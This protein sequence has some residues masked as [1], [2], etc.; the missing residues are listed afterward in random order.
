MSLSKRVKKK[1]SSAII[2]YNLIENND[3]ILVAVSGGKDSLIMLK[4]LAEAREN[5]FKKYDIIALHLKNELIE[6]SKR[7][8]IAKYVK[9]FCEEQAVKLII[10]ELPVKTESKKDKIGCFWCSWIRR[11]KIFETAEKYNISKVALGHHKDDIIETLLLNLFYHGKFATMPVKLQI[12][13]G[14]I[15]IIRPMALIEE[16]EIEKLVKGLEIKTVKCACPFDGNTK[17]EYIK[18]L[19]NNLEKEFKNIRVSLF[20]STN[21]EKIEKIYLN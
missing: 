10:D 5:F 19:I 7:E 15:T 2:K 17:R 4:F 1:F 13:D 6:N 18:N 14:K 8:E 21:Y 12:F 16:K 9:K 3:K 20:N 11:K